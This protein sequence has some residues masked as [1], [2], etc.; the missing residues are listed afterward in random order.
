MTD[1]QWET[2]DVPR[3]AYISWGTQPGQTVTG[4]VLDFSPLGGTDFNDEPCPQLSLEL[5]EATYSI[6]KLGERTNFAAGELVVL[7]CGQAS[8]KR[9]VRAAGPNPGDLVKIEFT[10]LAKGNKGDVKEFS[11]K[12]ARGVGLSRPANRASAPQSTPATW[13]AQT[14]SAEPPF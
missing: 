14:Q 7:N 5:V 10:S 6:N 3:G 4:K 11:I 12:I 9:A 2:V 13:G 8:L 1:P